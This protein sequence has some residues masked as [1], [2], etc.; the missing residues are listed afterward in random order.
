[1]PIDLLLA[2][3]GFALA[4]SITPGPNN[5]MLMTSGVNYGF[6]R[7]LPHMAGVASG[8]FAMLLLVGFGVGQ[9]LQTTPAL[10]LAL[11]IVSVVYL[12]WLAWRVATSGPVNPSAVADGA[13]PMNYFEAVLFQGV[14]PK[15]WAMAVTA[16]AAYTVPADYGFSLI[17]I[18][19]VFVLIG[20]PCMGIWTVFGIGMRSLL[21]DPAR[22][23]IFNIAMA[24]LLVLSFLPV[25]LDIS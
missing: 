2:F 23:R 8:F 18:S 6:R 22:V 7:S 3:A 12:L 14:N 16:A 5:I 15:A 19:V 9:L 11:K 20:T 4:S 1:M 10:Y 24:I 13:R 25:V 21:Q 17:V